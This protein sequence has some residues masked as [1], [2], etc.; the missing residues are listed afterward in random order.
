M[1]DDA[2]PAR[3]TWARKLSLGHLSPERPMYFSGLRV[4][5][6]DVKSKSL[7]IPSRLLKWWRTSMSACC[8]FCV[9]DAYQML[10]TLM[11]MHC[12]DHTSS[13]VTTRHTPK[14][15]MLARGHPSRLIGRRIRRAHP[16]GH[17]RLHGGIIANADQALDCVR[18]RLC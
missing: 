7:D 3:C 2:L 18:G 4:K 17:E 8:T 1:T 12:S 16:S 9:S 11:E 10:P 14:S 15:G 13:S 5:P 6:L